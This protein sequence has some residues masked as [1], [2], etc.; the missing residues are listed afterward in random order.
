[1]YSADT[2]ACGDNSNNR[3]AILK[4]TSTNL[5]VPIVTLSTKDNVNFTKK[6]NEEFKRSVYWK[7]YK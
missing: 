4:I 1:M 5:Y 2:Y 3:E 6:L 7:E